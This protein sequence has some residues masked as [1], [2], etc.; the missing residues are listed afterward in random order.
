MKWTEMSDRQRYLDKAIQ[1]CGLQLD[2]SDVCLRKVMRAICAEESEAIFVKQ[3][4]ELRLRTSSLLNETDDF[5]SIT[6]KK[7]N[8]F[9]KEDK[10]WR[11][12]GRALGFDF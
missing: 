3:R 7:L 6:E 9:E 11:R 4:I 10:E 2:R 12:K 5:I 8:E 1:Q